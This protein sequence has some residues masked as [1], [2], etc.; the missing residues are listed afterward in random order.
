MYH[1]D[2]I[3]LPGLSQDFFRTFVKPFQDFL[4][5]FVKPFQDFFCGLACILNVKV[6]YGQ[7]VIFR[8][9]FQKLFGHVTSVFLRCSVCCIIILFEQETHH[10]KEVRTSQDVCDN[11]VIYLSVC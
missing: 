1:I 9:C 5:T 3:G 8:C 2:I 6:F 7:T 11:N 4:R 10:M